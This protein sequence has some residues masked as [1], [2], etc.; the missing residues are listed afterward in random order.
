MLYWSKIAG[1]IAVKQSVCN[2][3]NKLQ[4]QTDA[5]G[6]PAVLQRTRTC[7][8]WYGREKLAKCAYAPSSEYYGKSLTSGE[9]MPDLLDLL[10]FPGRVVLMLQYYEHK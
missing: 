9:R 2:N 1:E 5:C 4:L 6:Y 7:F 10:Y 8:S 3:I